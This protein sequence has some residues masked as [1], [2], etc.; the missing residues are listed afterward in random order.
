MALLCLSFAGCFALLTGFALPD[1]VLGFA[2][3]AA[4]NG[5]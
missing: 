3:L 1:Q 2:L 4:I 5:G